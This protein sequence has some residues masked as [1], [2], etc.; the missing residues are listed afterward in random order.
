NSGKRQLLV[1]AQ[2]RVWMGPAQHYALYYNRKDSVY[3][4]I[5]LKSNR[6]I[7][8]TKGLGVAFYDERNDTPSE[9]YPYG[10]AGWSEGDKA[11]YAYDRYDIWKLDPS[12]RKKPVRLTQNGREEK[13]VYRYLSL[14]RDEKYMGEDGK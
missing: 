6:H 7:P 11:V 1:K 5:D 2:N 12:G 3:Y 8:L 14:N 4:S 9:P 10:I 13:T